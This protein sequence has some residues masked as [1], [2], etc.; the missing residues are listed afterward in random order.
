MIGGLIASVIL[1]FFP[2]FLFALVIYW[3]DRYEKEP[4]V[5]LGAAFLWGA[6]ISSGAAFLLNSILGAGI[7]FISGSESAANFSVASIIAP[8]VEE[9]FKGI[10]VL[11]VFLIFRTE[12]DSI[13][14]GIVYAA[15]IAL[16]FAAAENTFYIFSMGFQS[17]GWPGLL[18]LA[19]IRI[20]L[21]GWQHPF[22]TAFIGIGIGIA[23][24]NKSTIIKLLTPLLGL[25]FAIFTHSLHNTLA[26]LLSY[27]RTSGGMILAAQLDWLG[28]GIMLIFIV[29]M[30]KREHKLLQMH[31]VEE[32]SYD[33]ITENQYKIILST[34]LR[35]SLKYKLHLSKNKHGK[36][37]L[38]QLTQQAAELAHKKHQYL[39]IGNES[40]NLEII[41]AIRKQLHTA[42]IG[43]RDLTQ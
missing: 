30:I 14:D 21:V 5:L 26:P 17:A 10:A 15:V 28:W 38:N 1:G 36:T 13:L 42:S 3:L 2:M 11:L 35:K 8:V 22:Y 29:L 43:L 12:F 25:C 23:R 41:Q 20:V 24:L 39:K 33:I 19:F 4:K 6:V 9:I 7:Y 34:N 40:N 32:I 16:G 37:A 18:E 31:L 27:V